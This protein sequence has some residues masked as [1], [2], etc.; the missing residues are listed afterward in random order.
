MNIEVF[1]DKRFSASAALVHQ[2][3]M[4]HIGG[5]MGTHD[6]SYVYALNSAAL[7]F[8]AYISGKLLM[9]MLQFT[10]QLNTKNLKTKT[11]Y[12]KIGTIYPKLCRSC[13]I[14]TKIPLSTNKCISRSTYYKALASITDNCGLSNYKHNG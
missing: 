9:A 3:V 8:Q 13:L 14:I 1:V 10:Q 2:R 11:Q 6:L 5:N 7:G 12:R 4:L